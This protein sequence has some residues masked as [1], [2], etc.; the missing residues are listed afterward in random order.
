MSAAPPTTPRPRRAAVIVFGVLVVATFAAF[1]VAQRLKN[2]PSVVQ[3]LK[4]ATGVHQKGDPPAFSPNGDGRRERARI[5]F[6]LKKADDVTVHILNADG[7]QVRKLIRPAPQGLHASS[8]RRSC[9][10]AATTAASCCP[11][12][13]TASRSRSRTSAAP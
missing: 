1:F 9:G 3:A 11:T 7:D 6:R 13:A 10:T 8:S 5:T 12:A 4:I 2:A